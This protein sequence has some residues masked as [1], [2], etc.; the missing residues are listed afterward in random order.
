MNAQES[1]NKTLKNVLAIAGF[2]IL[3]AIGIWSA[4]QVIKFVPRLFGDTGVS[5]TVSD[6]NIV[7]GNR[8]ILV[9]LT[10]ETVQSGEAVLVEWAR[11]GSL[12][13]GVLSFSYACTEGFYFQVAGRPVACNAPLK[14]PLT[15]T[16]LEV[17][18]ISARALVEAPL[19]ITYTNADGVSVRDTKTLTVTNDTVATD[20]VDQDGKEGTVLTETPTTSTETRTPI[21]PKPK[22]QV[23]A[24]VTTYKPTPK[25]VVTTVKVPRQSDPYGTADLKVE[26]VAIGEINHYG[27]FEHKHL[28]NV[29]ARGG[30]KFKVTNLGTKATGPWYFAATLPTQGGYPYSSGPQPSLNPGSST[31]IFVTFDQLVPGVHYFDVTVDPYNHIHEWSDANNRATQALTVTTY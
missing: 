20:T 12:E 6:S 31:E 24:P 22:T 18:A 1:S 15:D 10:P 9:R 11:N 21:E 27:A 26:M 5:N 8:D 28:V 2:I 29:Y 19:A 13:E 16:S 25:P 23:A 7:L 4:I 30:A 17:V 3:L 14:L